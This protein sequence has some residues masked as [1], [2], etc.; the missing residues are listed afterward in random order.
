[1]NYEKLIEI[2]M[3]ISDRIEEVIIRNDF[4]MNSK[5]L[6]EIHKYIFNGILL[7]N[8]TGSIQW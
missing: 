6:K 5:Y 3:I 7:R 2:R 1:M 8:R 4:E